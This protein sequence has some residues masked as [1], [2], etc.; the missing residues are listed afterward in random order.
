MIFIRLPPDGF[1]LGFDSLSG[2]EDDNT[3]VED[4]QGAFDFGSE[5]NVTRRVDE[6]E[7]MP[8]SS[9]ISPIEGNACGLDG[10]ASFLFFG[11]VIGNGS[12]LIDHADFVYEV[13]I[14]EHPFGN[15]RFSS[16]D[17]GDDAD[18]AD[19]LQCA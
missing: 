7:S 3:A 5:V 8:C 18:V 17:M 1:A 12:A 16:V 11:I 6:I 14:E 4:A 15:G 9:R 13:G 19:V 10:D 2:R